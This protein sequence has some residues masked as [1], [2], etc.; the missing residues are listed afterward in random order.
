MVYEVDP[1]TQTTRVVFQDNGQ[2]IY[3]VSS[4]QLFDDRLYLGQLFDPY[5]LSCPWTQNGG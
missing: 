2:G 3:A 1:K 4:S 5:I